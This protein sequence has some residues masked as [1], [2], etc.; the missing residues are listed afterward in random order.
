M[1]P[2]AGIKHR[3][4]GRLTRKHGG[5]SGAAGR[6]GRLPAP[7]H[8]GP[9]RQRHPGGDAHLPGEELHG[10]PAGLQQKVSLEHYGVETYKRRAIVSVW[11]I[12]AGMLS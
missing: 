7:G 5:G 12:L 4:A 1:A 9:R 11:L 10:H 3:R 8:C 2:L 6:A